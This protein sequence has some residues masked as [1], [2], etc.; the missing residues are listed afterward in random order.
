M[1]SIGTSTF[2]T[3]KSRFVNVV[4][5][6]RQSG[7]IGLQALKQTSPSLHQACLDGDQGPLRQLSGA[8]KAGG[9]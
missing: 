9:R 5:L 2:R 7:S 6:G 1:S 8:A 4:A 3:S